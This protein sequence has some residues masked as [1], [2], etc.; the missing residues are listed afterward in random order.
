MREAGLPA[1]A[2]RMVLSRRK[3]QLQQDGW[4]KGRMREDT[5]NQ[6]GLVFIHFNLGMAMGHP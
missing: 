5:V 2:R 1:L 6:A 3:I 4:P